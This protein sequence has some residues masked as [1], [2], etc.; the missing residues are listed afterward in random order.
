MSQWSKNARVNNISILIILLISFLTTLILFF[1]PYPYRS[2]DLMECILSLQN[3]KFHHIFIAVRPILPFLAIISPL[4]PELTLSIISLCSFIASYFICSYYVKSLFP[5]S[6]ISFY[7]A[8]FTNFV[9]PLILTSS[10]RMA[11][12]FSYFLSLCV[13]ALFVKNFKRE[14]AKNR[15]WVY[16][17]L[18]SGLIVLVRE[19]IW[20]SIIA[21]CLCLLLARKVKTLLTYILSAIIIPVTWNLYT[22][23]SYGLNY[24]TAFYTS[25]SLSI[26]YS[27]VAYN[28][29]KVLGY[30][31]DGLTP[32]LLAFTLLWILNEVDRDRFKLLHIISLPFISAAILWPGLYEPRIVIVALPAIA[33]LTG[34][35]A[36]ILIERLSTQPIYGKLGRDRIEYA[37]LISYFLF[38]ILMAYLNNGLRF[39]YIFS[40]IY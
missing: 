17:G 5:S 2:S 18:F 24:L 39:S 27:G 14:L 34:Y 25:V 3:G 31:I 19:N 1:D 40:K 10:A 16:L 15:L 20:A 28:P 33:P 11:D 8:Y 21:V 13:L 36:N 38:N 9:F 22:S 37:V 30:F 35:G 4:P 12:A 29:W 6:R 32:F 23:F 7:G 26:K